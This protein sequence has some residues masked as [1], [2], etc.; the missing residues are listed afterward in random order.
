VVKHSALIPIHDGNSNEQ[1]DSTSTVIPT[2]KMIPFLLPRLSKN[3]QELCAQQI[4]P[5][6]FNKLLESLLDGFPGSS[7][8]VWCGRNQQDHFFQ[9]V[10]FI[11]RARCFF[12]ISK[13]NHWY[14]NLSELLRVCVCCVCVNHLVNQCV[15]VFCARKTASTAA[16]YRC[17][18]KH[19]T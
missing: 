6:T 19:S 5:S 17:W 2:N 15:C 9:L 4:S 16:K 14:D 18:Y 8:Y 3:F 11:S 1:D 12:V 7:L 13:K 10:H